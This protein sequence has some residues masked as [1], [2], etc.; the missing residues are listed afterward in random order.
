VRVGV[1]ARLQH[2][3]KIRQ[4]DPRAENWVPI[5]A[6]TWDQDP[7]KTG[8]RSPSDSYLEMGGGAVTLAGTQDSQPTR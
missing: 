4:W 2:M 3:R 7:E 5:C 6:S 8:S 1:S